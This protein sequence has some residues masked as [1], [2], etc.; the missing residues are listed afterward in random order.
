VPGIRR[1]LYDGRRVQVRLLAPRWEAGRNH[2]RWGL[3]VRVKDMRPARLRDR[4]V[5]HL[6]IFMA[7]PRPGQRVAGGT[8]TLEAKTWLAFLRRPA[9]PG[10]GASRKA[11]IRLK[12]GLGGGF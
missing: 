1:Y 5:R 12:G 6:E 3:A 11:F 4:H 2:R 8:V 10:S 7:I 9:G